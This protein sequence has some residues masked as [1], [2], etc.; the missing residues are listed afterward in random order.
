[1]F[2]ISQIAVKSDNFRQT[3]Q[4]RLADFMPKKPTRYIKRYA[5]K[6]YYLVDYTDNIYFEGMRCRKNIWSI[7]YR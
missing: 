3:N 6:K 2:F 1:V 5:L 7:C 4:S